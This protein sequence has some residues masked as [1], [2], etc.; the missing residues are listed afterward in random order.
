MVNPLSTMAAPGRHHGGGPAGIHRGVIGRV[1][2][3][4][5]PE[6]ITYDPDFI[7]MPPRDVVTLTRTRTVLDCLFCMFINA[8]KSP[9]W[10]MAD[11]QDRAW[12]ALPEADGR[13]P[14][15]RRAIQVIPPLPLPVIPVD[16]D[17][18][19]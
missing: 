1:R 3:N 2:T 18:N 14:I 5:W 7:P 12:V 8:A 11:D 17:L 16:K 10:D 13:T 19:P 9:G 15:V 6:R 4:A